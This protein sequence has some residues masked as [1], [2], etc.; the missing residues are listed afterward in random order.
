MSQL[1]RVLALPAC[2]FAFNCDCRDTYAQEALE[3][4]TPV[5][6]DPSRSEHA[7]PDITSNGETLQDAWAIALS[8]DPNLEAS[9]WQ[10]SAA[11]RGLHAARAERLPSVSVRSSYSVYDNPLTLNS[12]VPPLCPIPPGTIASATVNQREF[13]LGGVRAMQPL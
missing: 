3:L 8:V 6:V 12:P 13:F 1:A 4:P 2:L 5:G 7:Q 9:R 11:Q 10:A